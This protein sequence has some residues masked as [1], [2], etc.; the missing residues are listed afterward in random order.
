MVKNMDTKD[1]TTEQEMMR[2]NCAGCG[3]TLSICNRGNRYQN[4]DGEDICDPCHNGARE[5]PP[6]RS[7]G[8]YGPR[9]FVEEE[10]YETLKEFREATAE[11]VATELSIPYR[12][13]YQRLVKL[14]KK[15]RATRSRKQT[16][17]FPIGHPPY[18][19]RVM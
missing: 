12:T 15:G 10:T 7:R 6:R 19:W 1:L 9:D 5:Q 8:Q 4:D 3:A 2:E 18:H 16:E 13:A 17:I 11:Q 14:M